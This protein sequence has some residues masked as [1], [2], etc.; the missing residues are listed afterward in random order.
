[1][2]SVYTGC[3]FGHR[4]ID[5]FRLVE[6]KV[7]TL[8]IKLLNEHEYVEFLIGRD[9]EFDQLVTSAILRCR[10][11]LD[12][13]NCSVTWVMP[14]LKADYVNNS[15][16]YDNYYDSVEVCEQSANAHPKAAI[17]IRNRA[18]VDR[19]DLCVFCVTHKSGGAYQTLRYAE[20]A[21][22]NIINLCE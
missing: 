8:I 22:S 3:F 5:D 1:M 14:Y 19:S 21:D 13:A 18:M 20:K 11:R 17:Q 9:G 12:T 16:S 4:Q 7:E 10:N 2:F 15:E 6:Q